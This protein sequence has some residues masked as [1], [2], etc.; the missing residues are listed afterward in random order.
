V[1]DKVPDG[2]PDGWL[3]LSGGEYSI[4]EV[5]EGELVIKG[6][7]WNGGRDDSAHD[8]LFLACDTAWEGNKGVSEGEV[9]A[10]IGYNG[11]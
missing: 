8:W 6:G 3:D 9:G 11:I 2:D 5:L 1:Y 10:L 7:R 4:G